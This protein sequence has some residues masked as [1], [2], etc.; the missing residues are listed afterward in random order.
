MLS[1]QNNT[2]RCKEKKNPVI[3]LY[4]PIFRYKTRNTV[5]FGGYHYKESS[6][7]HCFV[8][9]FLLFWKPVH[10][11]QKVNYTQILIQRYT[12]ILHW[13]S[14]TKISGDIWCSK[15][16]IYVFL[17]WLVIKFFLRS[18]KKKSTYEFDLSWFPPFSHYFDIFQCKYS[19]LIQFKGGSWF[20]FPL[21]GCKKTNL[22]LHF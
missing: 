1:F 20:E 16:V 12:Q 10:I 17:L 14:G 7:L 2:C 8:R 19:Y 22:Y 6:I 21:L 3:S 5:H 18:E 4:N 13:K 9:E 15:E 11:K